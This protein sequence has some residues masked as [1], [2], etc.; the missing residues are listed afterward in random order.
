M[1][2]HKFRVSFTFECEEYSHPRSWVPGALNNNLEEGERVGKFV[3]KPVEENF[4]TP[5]VPDE[6]MEENFNTPIVPD[7]TMDQMVKNGVQV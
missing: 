2:M 3:Y 4:N 1:A 7:E 6:T 5:I